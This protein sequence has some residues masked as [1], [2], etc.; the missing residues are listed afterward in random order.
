MIVGV[1]QHGHLT[2]RTAHKSSEAL[3]THI[4]AAPGLLGNVD[5]GHTRILTVSLEVSARQTFSR[6]RKPGRQ[7]HFPTGFERDVGQNAHVYLAMPR[8]ERREDEHT[9]ARSRG[10]LVMLQ[11]SWAGDS[12]GGRSPRQHQRDEGQV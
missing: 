7:A 9:T 1:S 2:I 8:H 4:Q 6:E 11:V 3:Q 5:E 12:T 10:G